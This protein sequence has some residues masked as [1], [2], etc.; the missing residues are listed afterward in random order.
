[1]QANGVRTAA[2]VTALTMLVAVAAIAGNQPMRR[3]APEP[4]QPTRDQLEGIG[5]ITS[6]FPVPGAL[7]PEVYP[8]D[9]CGL[10]T[11][12]DLTWL[13]VVMSAL[14]VVGLLAAAFVLVPQLLRWRPRWPRLRWRGRRRRSGE[15]PATEPTVDEPPPVDAEADTEVARRAV[16]AALVRLREPADP[17]GAVID[18]YARM[19]DVLASRELGRRI[20]EA[21]REYLRRVLREQ[22]MPERSL[23]TLTQ[24]FEEARFSPHPIPT[25][26]SARARS[27]L[28][29]AR[30]ALR[31]ADAP[32]P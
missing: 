18:A 14:G 20:P 17:R 30:E 1:M 15:P 10:E 29:I 13:L 11:G 26:A 3:F 12:P 6:D 22:G 5:L 8:P 24:L 28:E 27:E 25:S 4:P 23:T 32:R 31:V 9:C 7:P 19:E 2:V 16:D 21:P